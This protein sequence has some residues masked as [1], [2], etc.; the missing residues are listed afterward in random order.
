M[1]IDKRE[2]KVYNSDIYLMRSKERYIL[3]NKR[4]KMVLL[5]LVLQIPPY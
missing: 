5:F 4:S 1:N 3:Y 2:G